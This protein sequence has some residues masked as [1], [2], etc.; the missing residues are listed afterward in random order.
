MS[1][2]RGDSD[3][4][5]FIQPTTLYPVKLSVI[6]NYLTSSPRNHNT[7]CHAPT[8]NHQ[9]YVNREKYFKPDTVQN[10]FCQ[11]YEKISVGWGVAVI[12]LK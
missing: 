11:S 6:K 4:N 9:Q 5:Y 2:R 8:L 3:L 7:A 10:T 1:R 12:Q